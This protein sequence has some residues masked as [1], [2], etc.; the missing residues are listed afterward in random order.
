MASQAEQKFIPYHEEIHQYFLSLSN[1][2]NITSIEATSTNKNDTKDR[3]KSL[4]AQKARAKL[5]KLSPLQFYELCTDVTDELN[6][7]I[8]ESRTK[9]E[10]SN[11]ST[12]INDNKQD[13]K[14]KDYLL[15]KSNYHVK[16]NQARQKL[17]N[18]SQLRFNDLIDDILFEM[19][20]RGYHIVGSDNANIEDS[21]ISSPEIINSED[22][23]TNRADVQEISENNIF[24]DNEHTIDSTISVPLPS[25]IQSSLIIPQKASID[26]SEEE[27]QEQEEDE[28]RDIESKP[29]NCENTMINK[30]KEEVRIGEINSEPDSHKGELNDASDNEVENGNIT[31]DLIRH[32][33]MENPFNYSTKDTTN[34]VSENDVIEIP[35]LK[36]KDSLTPSSS[37]GYTAN[38]E[39]ITE[40]K[41]K[42]SI[43]I[44]QVYNTKEDI[45]VK[46]RDQTDSPNDIP[47][48]TQENGNTTKV[49]CKNVDDGQSFNKKD[50]ESEMTEPLFAQDRYED[51]SAQ[52]SK[53]SSNVFTA[54]IE[55]PTVPSVLQ[56]PNSN[57]HLQ[58]ELILLNKQLTSLSIENEKLKTKIS[59]LEVMNSN[60]QNIKSNSSTS[61]S[62]KLVDYTNSGKDD[63]ILS[64]LKHENIAQF[65][66]EYGIIPETLIMQ[67]YNVVNELYTHIDS[68]RKS[69]IELT[70]VTSNVSF[71]RSLFQLINQ[72]YGIILKIIDLLSQSEEKD[73]IV[74]L[75]STFSN[76]ITT[77]KYFALYYHIL[78]DIVIIS[79]INECI[80]IIMDIVNILKV[81]GDIL[82]VSNN[83]SEELTIPIRKA[84]GDVSGIPLTAP[85]DLI[86]SNSSSEINSLDNSPVKPLRIIEKVASSPLITGTSGN[87]TRGTASAMRKPSNNVLLSLKSMV[88]KTPNEKLVVSKDNKNTKNSEIVLDTSSNV[89]HKRSAPNLINRM[90]FSSSLVS[91]S[92]GSEN[93]DD[94]TED[95]LQELRKQREDVG[96]QLHETPSLN[97][98]TDIC[99][100]P[101]SNNGQRGSLEILKPVM[102]L[103]DKN[104]LKVTLPESEL[105]EKDSLKEQLSYQERAGKNELQ[106]DS[107]VEKSELKEQ[108]SP[109]DI[110]NKGISDVKLPKQESAE[111]NDLGESLSE[112]GLSDKSELL[113]N[114]NK[115]DWIYKQK[116]NKD[117]SEQE[118]VEKCEL[119]DKFSE[120]DMSYRNELQEKV[121][122]QGLVHE[123]KLKEESS[124][125][126]LDIPS[127]DVFSEDGTIPDIKI[128]NGLNEQACQ[129][130][131]K[132]KSQHH[133]VSFHNNDSTSD[134]ASYATTN[135][136]LPSE[137][138]IYSSEYA[139]TVEAV[140]PSSLND[141]MVESP[142]IQ[143]VTD[144]VGQSNRFGNSS[145]QNKNEE[146]STDSGVSST[147]MED[148][149]NNNDAI[150][151]QSSKTSDK[152]D[153]STTTEMDT[154]VSTKDDNPSLPLNL[155]TDSSLKSTDLPLI[156]PFKIMK[157][158]SRSLK[159][160]NVP[161]KDSNISDLS[162]TVGDISTVDTSLESSED[163]EME[164]IGSEE[165]HSSS[166][167]SPGKLSSSSVT[168][169]QKKEEVAN[170]E[171]PEKDQVNNFGMLDNKSFD[172]E[173]QNS[174]KLK[175]SDSHIIN[176][177]NLNN[178]YSRQS[179]VA[180]H[181]LES[182][183]EQLL[184]KTNFIESDNAQYNDNNVESYI[185]RDDLDLNQIKKEEELSDLKEVT[186]I[187][188]SKQNGDVHE[189]TSE[190]E[191]IE[192]I[193][194]HI[195]DRS[196]KNGK[197]F[198]SNHIMDDDDFQ[199]IPLQ[200]K[201]NSD[202]PKNTYVQNRFISEKGEPA[203]SNKPNEIRMPNKISED[204]V[205]DSESGSEEESGTEGSGSESDTE[206]ESES[207]TVSASDSDFES[208]SDSTEERDYE[209]EEE[210]EDG[211]MDFDV[212][213]FD[214]E[215]PDNTLSE[216]LLYL[217]HQTVQVITTIQSLLTSIKEPK[218]TKGNL[219]EES[220]AINQVI[221]QMVG[222][223]S[224]SMNQSRNANLKEHGSWVVQSL[225]DCSRRM[226]TLCQLNPDGEIKVM[227]NDIDYADKNFKQR[228]AGIAFDI[229][230]CT[231][232]LV[233]TVEEASLKEEIEF[234]NSK[235]HKK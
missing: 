233:K 118:L 180:I 193:Q 92:S 128:G 99:S 225:E 189:N 83:S 234:L 40:D 80:F 41:T 77:S 222:A 53:Q 29:N 110:V 221:K 120:G 195:S 161:S 57:S 37:K 54:S 177:G 14:S 86:S 111:E 167:N 215:N 82:V 101:P 87:D 58:N 73:K 18:L 162:K 20:R 226:I 220:N 5:L 131:T 102:T 184:Q 30:P 22:I 60:Q 150:I 227:D 34:T 188:E 49:N 211:E 170:T 27:E 138:N 192:K 213:A 25:G 78:P 204:S 219:R 113:D 11:S 135:N 7:R 206:S 199:F 147:Q 205:T 61:N 201:N 115:K 230:K 67:L 216:L 32:N 209:E 98:D 76:L 160:I 139:S 56:S 163:R 6:R 169:D 159:K 50:K 122:E 173:L 109:Q 79:S 51:F 183:D 141:N 107:S 119:K 137:T 165:Q 121:S 197:E 66:K 130:N 125:R 224:I 208:G 202:V 65:I 17:S 210:E 69:N 229:A 112:Q 19:R 142:A 228:L 95:L 129:S 4:R 85:S 31:E 75:K 235:I 70:N 133:P 62:S 185:S 186:M 1:F 152:I 196:I 175:M 90:S 116:P 231:K 194:R 187:H 84:N 3:S 26:W 88:K 158:E 232:E 198:N 156:K 9:N 72:F 179:S 200:S 218:S 106:A 103:A 47:T 164:V 123:H 146:F 64:S 157:L 217:E 91:S 134:A 166:K 23:D 212:E 108:L 52:S 104:T 33:S 71:G 182:L 207:A 132:A 153:E 181:P 105:V 35:S 12:S 42:L 145:I 223:T 190:H 174:D 154:S 28:D 44:P 68:S 172:V 136:E 10:N 46:S 100:V 24:N 178:N 94:D 45:S 36:S 144:T 89:L 43:G 127:T 48:S 148:V 171:I 21:K 13:D 2:L 97:T 214:I 155:N 74:L 59:E 117:L 8:R 191:A 15:P 124:E 63:Y 114:V 203:L 143:E 38:N 96:S 39:N 126:E 140:P 55:Q 93:D 149:E 16:R 168:S 176:E 151:L 81:K